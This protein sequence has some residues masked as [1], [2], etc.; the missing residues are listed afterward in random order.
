MTILERLGLAVGDT[1]TAR[2]LQHRLRERIPDIGVICTNCTSASPSGWR[3]YQYA[4][5]AGLWP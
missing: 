1:I 2:E 4:I 5:Q 3:E